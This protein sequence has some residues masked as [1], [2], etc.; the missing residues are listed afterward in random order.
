MALRKSN[1]GVFLAEIPC[2]RE[3]TGNFAFFGHPISAGF[4]LRAAEF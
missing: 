3:L 4:A 2:F 1:C